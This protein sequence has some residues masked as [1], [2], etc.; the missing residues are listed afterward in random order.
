MSFTVQETEL[1][2]SDVS[3]KNGPCTYL[4]WTLFVF[5]P[6][7]IYFS[8]LAIKVIFNDYGQ[9]T[10][11]LSYGGS[12]VLLKYVFMVSTILTVRMHSIFHSTEID[13]NANGIFFLLMEE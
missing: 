5:R 13:T 6:N 3:K 2:E 12:V 4:G 1:K 8:N 7:I 10:K 9:H 11:Q